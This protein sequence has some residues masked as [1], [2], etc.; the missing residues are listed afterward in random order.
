MN[1]NKYIKRLEEERKKI[2]E[3]LRRIEREREGSKEVKLEEREV[4]YMGGEG[5]R[6][7]IDNMKVRKEREREKLKQ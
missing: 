7:I 1:N 4:K 6:R 3:K 5:A 2:E